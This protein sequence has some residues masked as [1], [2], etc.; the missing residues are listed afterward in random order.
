MTTELLKPQEAAAAVAL[1]V[2]PAVPIG[3]PIQSR[4][5][6]VDVAA[7][8][9]KQLRRGA[10]ARVPV[11]A[12]APVKLE[13]VAMAEVESRLIEYTLPPAKPATGTAV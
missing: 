4:F 7:L 3:P 9:A 11:P 13:R 10:Q 5:L 12:D 2:E 6:F 1:P 8:R